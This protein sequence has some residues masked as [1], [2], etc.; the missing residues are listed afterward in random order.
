MTADSS[1]RPAGQTRLIF[2]GRSNRSRTMSDRPEALASRGAWSPY[3]PDRAAP[4][5]LRRVV[6]LHRRAGFAATWTE[7]QRD[8]A[9]RPGASIDRLLAGKARPP[10]VPE[11][12][13]KTA[14][15]LADTAQQPERLK[16]SGA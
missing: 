8:L 7:I 12:F 16:A 4:W 2:P 13:E 10:G 14:S 5:D 11:G 9:D 1:V 6:H 15:P 3:V